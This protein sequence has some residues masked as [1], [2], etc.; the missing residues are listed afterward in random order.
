M[1]LASF[2]ED[3]YERYSDDTFTHQRIGPPP[4]PRHRCPLCS[5][6]FDDDRSLMHHI[7]DAHRGDPP[8]LLIAGRT[9]GREVVVIRAFGQDEVSVQNCTE[10]WVRESPGERRSYAPRQL[11]RL[12]ASLKDALVDLELLNRF[13]PLADPLR[14]EFRLHLRIA[15]KTELDAIDRAFVDHLARDAVTMERVAEFLGDQRC[16]SVARPYAD[17][18]SKFVIGVLIRD[19][20]PNSGISLAPGEAPRE[21]GAALA[22]LEAFDRPLPR[23]VCGLIRFTQNDFEAAAYATGFPRLDRCNATFAGLIGKEATI[24]ARP[25]AAGSGGKSIDL[26]PIDHATD[27]VLDLAD[28]LA[29]QK[30]WGPMLQETCRQTAGLSIFAAGDRHKALTLWAASALRLNE[31]DEA[32]EPLRQLRATY[33][34]GNWADGQLS[35]MEERRGRW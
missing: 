24:G 20:S 30:H 15:E 17:A 21:L 1:A 19:Q 6:S 7:G 33:P 31:P 27:R 18:L 5:K 4:P 2:R 12:L 10:V 3:I 26:C 9:P 22:A 25:G 13:E 8:V 32:M 34:F 14:S 29:R 35:R 28:S 16:Q 23:V 11:P